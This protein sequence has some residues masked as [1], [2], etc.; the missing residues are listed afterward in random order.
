MASIGSTKLDNRNTLVQHRP[1]NLHTG[2]L[3]VEGISK[4]PY[5]TSLRL[6]ALRSLSM[7]LLQIRWYEMTVSFGYE[8]GTGR[9]GG[10]VGDCVELECVTF[11]VSYD[12]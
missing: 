4:D 12:K 1:K 2:I 9:M 5:A 3:G 10:G 11:F 7:A 6:R 8:N